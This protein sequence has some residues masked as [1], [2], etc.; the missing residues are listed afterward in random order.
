MARAPERL[1][2]VFASRRPPSVAVAEL[3]SLGELAELGI[4]DLRFSDVE[5]EQLVR[6]TLTGASSRTC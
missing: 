4:A 2:I 5:M 6:E 1:T 3:R